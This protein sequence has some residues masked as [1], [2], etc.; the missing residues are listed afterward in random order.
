MGQLFRGKTK[1]FRALRFSKQAIQ[2][3]LRY[4]VQRVGPLVPARLNRIVS[5]LIENVRARVAPSHLDSV[6]PM[7]EDESLR[8]SQSIRYTSEPLDESLCIYA[9]GDVHGRADLLDDLLG[10]IEADAEDWQGCIHLI[11]LGDYVDRGLESRRVI[12]TLIGL[13]TAECETTFL[14]GNHEEAL[15]AFLSDY[16]K[17]PIW[18]NYGGR[19]TLV[20]YGVRP[21]RSLAV[22]EDWKRAHEDFRQAL[23]NEHELFL[24]SLETNTRIGPFGFVHAGVRPGVPFEHQSD[25]D[26]LWIRDSFLK[27]KSPEDLMIVH[28]HTPTDVPYAD[29]RRIGIDTGAYFTGRL[30][31]VR[32]IGGEYS[33]LSTSL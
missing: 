12:E 8:P 21:P 16:K 9:V 2:R 31:A 26:R 19:E 6:D 17:G 14:K 13:Q 27:S 4:I 29:A 24:K 30:S 18:A 11:F 10:L 20:S 5:S 33:F 23:P 15:L 32:I 1:L 7:I 22:S 28:G 25:R 3:G